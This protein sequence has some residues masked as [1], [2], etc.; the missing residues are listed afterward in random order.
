VYPC[1]ENDDVLGLAKKI[2]G[3]AAVGRAEVPWKG[4]F[5]LSPLSFFKVEAG[6]RVVVESPNGATCS[7]YAQRAPYVFAGSLLNVQAVADAVSRILDGSDL[8][9]TI[10]ACGERDMETSDGDQFRKAVE[11]YLGAGAILACLSHEKSDYATVCE[12]SF[13][14]C[15]EKIGRIVWSGRSGREL[16]EMGFEDDIRHSTQMDIY[17]CVPVLC[18]GFFNNYRR[19]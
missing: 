5:S 12:R 7:R 11:D 10:I 13:R 8:S 19:D 6:T 1:A 2:G 16:R 15:R 14:F 4:R 9:A 17:D 3:E 18:D